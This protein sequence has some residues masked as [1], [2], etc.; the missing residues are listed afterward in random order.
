MA[1]IKPP[2]NRAEA[3]AYEKAMAKYR[4]TRAE[5][6]QAFFDSEE[7]KAFEASLAKLVEEGLPVGTTTAGNIVQLPRWFSD[8]RAQTA[9]DIANLNMVINP[10]TT[11]DQNAGNV[12][13]VVGTGA[14]EDDP[15]NT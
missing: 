14:A 13:N 12:T 8:V 5:E 3:E 4:L 1:D 2:K 10:P 7:T 6:V 9:N 11:A 15:K